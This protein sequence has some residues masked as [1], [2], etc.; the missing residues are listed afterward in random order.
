MNGYFLT[1]DLHTE[2]IITSEKKLA[3]YTDLHIFGYMF[4]QKI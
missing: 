3:Y 4:V 1:G 2:T